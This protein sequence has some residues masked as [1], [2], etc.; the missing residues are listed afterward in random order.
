MV[1]KKTGIKLTCIQTVNLYNYD[2]Y[3]ILFEFFLILLKDK[4][5]DTSECPK[6]F[7]LWFSGKHIITKTRILAW[8]LVVWL[9]QLYP[10]DLAAIF[11]TLVASKNVN[12][13]L[14]VLG[15]MC[16]TVVR[17][18]ASHHYGPGFNIQIWLHTVCESSLLV[19]SCAL[20]VF[21]WVLQFSFFCKK[22]TSKF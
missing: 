21:L 22:L 8:Y 10:F 14:Y 11:I 18:L 16:G 12:N 4:M 20:K 6:G 19:L 7:L 9:E 3:A 1:M 5:A 13:I 2:R 17:E 15:S